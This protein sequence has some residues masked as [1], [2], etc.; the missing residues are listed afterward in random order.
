MNLRLSIYSIFIGLAVC[1]QEKIVNTTY[2]DIKDDLQVALAA[3]NYSD[4]VTLI[5]KINV[6]DSIYKALS[7]TK[8]YALLQSEDYEK[9]IAFIDKT[10][11]QANQ[12]SKYSLLLNR[13]VSYERWDKSDQA[14]RF[15]DQLIDQYPKAYQPHYNKAL[16][17]IGKENWNEAYDLLEKSLFLSPFDKDTHYKIG[18]IYFIEGKLSQALM[19]LSMSLFTNPDSENSFEYLKLINASFSRKS[20]ETPRGVQ[21]T[22]DDV[23]FK[24]IDL[25]LSNGVALNEKYKIKNKIKIPLVKQL[26]VLFEQIETLE[27]NGEFWAQKMIPFFKWIKSSGN[28]DNFIH[29][30]CYSIENPSYKKIVVKN[31][32]KIISFIGQANAK[33]QEI[34]AKDNLE[35]FEGKEQLVNYLYDD[36]E[37]LALGKAKGELKIGNWNVYNSDGKFIRKGAFNSEG[38][39]DGLWTSYDV[40]G[41]KTQITS[42]K[43]G[44]PDGVLTEFYSDGKIAYKYSYKEGKLNGD[45][46]EYSKNGKLKTH[47][48][49][50]DDKLDG[51][52]KTYYALGE[53]TIE[54]SITYKDGKLDGPYKLFY[55][56]GEKYSELNYKDGTFTGQE[57]TYYRDGTIRSKTDY[58]NNSLNGKYITYYKNGNVL[59]D[60]NYLNDNRSGVWKEFY[61]DGTLQEQFEY[62]SK[63]KLKGSYKEFDIDGKLHS[64]F[65]YKNG[66]IVSYKYLNKQGA[67]LYEVKRKSGKLKYKGYS[68][69]GS[70][71][72]EGVYNVKG[73]KDGKWSY[74][75]NGALESESFYEDGNNTGQTTWFYL[76]KEVS[77]KTLYKDDS[78]NGY[79]VSYYENGQME[80]QGF[81]KDN[82][83]VGEWRS[84]HL[85]G[86]IARIRFYHKDKLHGLDQNFAVDGKLYSEK[87]YV[88]GDFKKITYF[89]PDG[90]ILETKTFDEFPENEILEYKHPNNKKQVSYTYEGG[91][92]HGAFNKYHFNGKLNIEGK[93]YLGEKHGEWKTFD[94][95]GLVT[96]TATYIHGKLE[97]KVTYFEEGKLS[98]I[99]HYKNG[100]ENGLN[101]MYYE[102]GKT[103]NKEFSYRND[104]SHGTYKFF[105]PNGKLQFVRFYHNGEL[106]GY[107]YEDENGKLKPM[108]PLP[109]QS[110]N[111]KTYFSNGTLAA[112]IQLKNGKFIGD[113]KKLHDNGKLHRL[114]QHNT[115]GSSKGEDKK[116]YSDGSL[117][118]ESKYEAGYRIEERKMY[119]SN[120]AVKKITNYRSGTRHGKEIEY[121]TNGEK[122][123][124]RTYFN[125]SIIDEKIF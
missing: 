105:A 1:A 125:G 123:K 89:N 108:I 120:G 58:T 96:K 118:E 23:A 11:P 33:W 100:K 72:S 67:T 64:D 79:S 26:S 30:I 61:E 21:Y 112:D 103:I 116:Y 110:G 91:V 28:V 78:K 44:K 113:Y 43:N 24:N 83:A 7:V 87:V 39:K 49:F 71:T 59:T 52:F 92:K 10:L 60:G 51:E 57:V 93:Y 85:D 114:D 47:K 36:K 34:V 104:K 95:A 70:L 84:Y 65:E 102:D 69:M 86:T 45:F 115:K 56:T 50:K 101:T 16:V 80:Y 13:A 121:N 66:L 98:E 19:S 31:Q 76:D 124:E 12:E 14:I 55:N 27:G 99:E 111:I 97:G 63:G 82:L 81:Y 9:A 4:C 53:K 75:E 46:F 90:T 88:Y 8:S 54:K 29:T 5:D 22:K 41:N 42:Y 32:S 40:D 20:K 109:N 62:D 38:L 119:F 107:S 6:N 117:K 15:Y 2:N 35:N 18:Q 48:I 68:P 73:G 74:Y 77:G 94:E 37:F 122:I 106:L 17:L 25:V 3:S